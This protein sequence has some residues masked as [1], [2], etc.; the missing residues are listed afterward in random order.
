MWRQIG[1]AASGEWFGSRENRAGNFVVERGGEISYKQTV[2][3]PAGG[4]V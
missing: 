4:E 2:Y 1:C 3:G